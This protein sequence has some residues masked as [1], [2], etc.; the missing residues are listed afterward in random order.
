MLPA[1]SVFPAVVELGIIVAQLV[2]AVSSGPLCSV[3]AHRRKQLA[4]SLCRLGALRWL[5]SLLYCL[6]AG[7]LFASL[8]AMEL[9]APVKGVHSSNGDVSWLTLLSQRFL[10][11][12]R[13]KKFLACAGGSRGYRGA[14]PAQKNLGEEKAGCRSADGETW[15]DVGSFVDHLWRCHN[16][17][18][19][20]SSWKRKIY[21][22][23]E[24]TVYQI[25]QCDYI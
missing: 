13:Q 18:V 8:R 7:R 21:Q 1:S 16:F 10:K 2:E 15:G 4:H 11:L 12:Q 17:L 9:V 3:S 6:K 22:K 14:K 20:G 19:T 24:T 25:T 5:G 23:M